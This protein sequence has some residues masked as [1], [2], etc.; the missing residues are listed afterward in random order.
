VGFWRNVGHSLFPALVPRRSTADRD[1]AKAAK[2]RRD[3][4]AGKRVPAKEIEKQATRQR[5]QAEQAEE[6]E[7]KRQRKESDKFY[8]QAWLEHRLSRPGRQFYKNYEFFNNLPM[9]RN[10]DEE[11]RQR[12]W[13]S[14]LENMVSG[15][16]RRD[17][18]TNPFWRQ[19]GITPRH[20]DWQEWRATMGYKAKAK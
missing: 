7:S 9:M 14:Y 4:K 6:R 20:F 17:N 13:E 3:F 5:E 18:P 2:A 19:S 15:H 11:I 12:L 8:R 10:E 16:H 1:K